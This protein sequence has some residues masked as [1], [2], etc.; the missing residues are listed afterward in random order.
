MCNVNSILLG[1]FNLN[2]AKKNDIN[3][4]HVRYF[5]DFENALSDKNLIQ[6]VEFPTWSRIVNN[7]LLESIIDH[8]YVKDPTLVSGIQSMKPLFGD[9]FLVSITIGLEKGEPDVS[10][11]RDWRKYSKE[12]LLG[13]LSLVDWA[14]E[15]NNVQNMWDAF[16]SKLVRIVDKI[17][18]LTEFANSKVKTKLPNSIKQK[19]N[20]GK[21]LFFK[22]QNPPYMA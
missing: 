16:E 5:D 19:I 3:Y 8:I 12:V 15:V 10:I 18:P 14:S 21:R 20:K 4:S 6:L 22:R 17:T 9:H 11:R 7:V 13:E 2:F 1:D